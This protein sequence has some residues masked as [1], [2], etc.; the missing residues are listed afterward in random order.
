[1]SA[2]DPYGLHVAAYTG[3]VGEVRR[4]L[5]DKGIDV[6]LLHSNGSAP[7][8]IAAQQGLNSI[9]FRILKKVHKQLK[10]I[11]L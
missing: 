5:G 4:L 10:K 9:H 1:M 6:N 2:K 8:Y 7:L 3:D 11:M